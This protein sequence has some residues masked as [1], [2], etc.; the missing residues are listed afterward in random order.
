M[1]Q[2]LT[3]TNFRILENDMGSLK[4]SKV[5]DLVVLIP[6]ITA[7]FTHQFYPRHLEEFHVCVDTPEND[8]YLH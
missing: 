8:E 1:R 7:M 4:R 6:D 3:A 2:S 5:M